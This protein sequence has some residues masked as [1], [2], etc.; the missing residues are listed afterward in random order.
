M[1]PVKMQLKPFV[2]DY[3]RWIVKAATINMFYNRGQNYVINHLAYELN[4]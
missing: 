1:V 3:T 2:A 4:S